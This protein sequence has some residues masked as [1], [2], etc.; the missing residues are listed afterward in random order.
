MSFTVDVNLLL[1]ASD[2]RSQFHRPASEFV[3]RMAAGTEI[4]YVFWPTLMAYLRIAT[5]PGI[6][7]RPLNLQSA[8]QN[9]SAL[10][11]LPH[12]QTPGEQD[13][14][15]GRFVEVAADVAPTGNLVPDA[16]IV[17]LMHQNGVDTIWTHDRDYRKFARITVRDPFASAASR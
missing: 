7:A 12:V 11:E 2:E 3:A 8:L 4:A 1:Y 5:H 10:V 6:F 14:F 16:H 15:W 13:D 9:I 17:G